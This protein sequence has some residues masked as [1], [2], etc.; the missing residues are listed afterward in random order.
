MEKQLLTLRSR[1]INLQHML[2]QAKERSRFVWNWIDALYVTNLVVCS[3]LLYMVLF[4][5]VV[6]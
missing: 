5:Q 6:L 3:T 4:R 1:T 2:F